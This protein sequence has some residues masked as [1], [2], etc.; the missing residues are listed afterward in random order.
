MAI[1][2]KKKITLEF[3][4]DEYKDSYLTFKSVSL[5]EYEQLIESLDKVT[6]DNSKSLALIKEILEKHYI[7]GVFE[8]EKVEVGDLQEFDIE[9][10]TTCFQ[11]FTGQGLNPKAEP[12]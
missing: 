10:I 4:G 9:T 3:L 6:E 8:G 11:K 2:I 5:K 12:Q 1:V 7:E